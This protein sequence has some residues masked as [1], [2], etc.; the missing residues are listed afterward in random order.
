MDIV[1]DIITKMSNIL[2]R[3]QLEQLRI[4]ITASLKD[5]DIIPKVTDVAIPCEEQNTLYLHQFIAWKY[6]EGRSK[7]SLDTYRF[8]IQKALDNI[9]LPVSQITEENVFLYL[10]WMKSQGASNTY[11]N[12]IRQYLQCFFTWLFNRKII[13]K[14]PMECIKPFKEE[15]VIREELSAV[16]LET[17]K[18]ATTTDRDLAIIEVLYST[19]VRVN[20]LTSMKIEDVD[21]NSGSIKVHGKGNKER[22]VYMSSTA[23]F[24]LKRYL[25]LRTQESEYVWISNNKPFGKMKNSGIQTLLNRLGKEC[26]IEKLHPHRFRRTCATNLLRKGMP[27][28]KVSKI[29]GHE[30]VETTMVYCN[31]KQEDVKNDYIKIMNI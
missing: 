25:E 18:R 1:I 30:S 24:Y 16:E 13:N 20:E 10:A 23:N 17:I 8:A 2:D 4:A 5:Y 28:E 22:E 14:N 12:N 29:L 27:L 7:S 31:I 21:F 6:T 11:L 9:K 19:G 15:K 26:K 3:Q